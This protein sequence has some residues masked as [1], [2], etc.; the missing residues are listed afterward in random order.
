M[1]KNSIAVCFPCQLAYCAELNNCA[2][3]RLF[4]HS[5][6][7]DMDLALDY[8]IE[9]YPLKK[10]ESF[11]L[12]LATSLLRP[13]E[14]GTANGADRGEEEKDMYVWRPDGK[15]QRGIDEDYEYVMYGRVCYINVVKAMTYDKY[16]DSG[17]QIRWRDNG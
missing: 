14:G 17:V 1:A 15:G 5:S 10:G 4:A 6:N 8:N 3:S 2:V 13:N 9:L 7:Y 12:V 11:T 16:H